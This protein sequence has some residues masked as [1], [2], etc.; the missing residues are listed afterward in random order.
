M[1]KSLFKKSIS[2]A[3]TLLLLMTIMCMAFNVNAA[4]SPN[5]IDK[6][7]TGSLTLTK[8]EMPDSEQA[9]GGSTGEQTDIEKL[10][11]GAIPLADVTF[12]MYKIG[13]I[14]TYFAPDGKP[15]PTVEEAARYVS[16]NPE[17]KTYSQTTNKDG[18]AK[19]T[20]LP[21]AIYYVVETDCPAQ[22]TKV[23]AP[24]VLSVPMTNADG[25]AWMYDIYS[26]PKN[27][28]AY[29]DI[30]L[31]KVDSVTKEEL[32]GAKFTLYHSYD[33]KTYTEYMTDL[34]TDEN[35]EF[36]VANLPSQVYYRFVES[37]TSDPSYILDTTAFYE[38]YIDGT[39]DV[40][41]NNNV[42]DD[43][44]IVVDNETPEIHKY[45]LDGEKG[46]KGIDNT[47]NY[48]DIVHWEIDTTIFTIVEKMATYTIVDTM[49]K[50][51]KYVDA[52][53]LVDNKKL[54]K[55][56]TD[57]TV[58]QSGLEVTF[59]IN[60]AVLDGGKEVN[61]YF[62]TELTTD[63]PLA[64]D[65]PNS[66]K[67]IY[68]ND[69]NT[70]STFEKQSEIPNVHTGGYSF[71]KT[72]GKSGLK[73]TKFAIYRTEKDADNDTNRIDTQVSGEDGLVEF[74]GLEYGGFSA[75]EETKNVNGTANGSTDYWIAEIEAPEGFNLIKEPFKVTVN[76][77]SHIASNN[78]NVVNTAQ[79]ELP[80]T[81]IVGG[82]V[83]PICGA[84]LF[85]SGLVLF[86]VVRI[87]KKNCIK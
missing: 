21:L 43:K 62:N 65:I 66:S 5:L 28:T 41:I 45:V 8:Y 14:D 29:S 63:A 30:N 31:K 86:G 33:N 80:Q 13:D 36:T 61:L 1:I 68:T 57:Y 84:I 44:T 75:D 3:L 34:T 87:K 27:Q 83:I 51:L 20:N 52:E 11:D 55:E 77:T 37:S 32:P 53:L 54:L 59:A 76:A 9:V 35:G 71:I 64:Q 49:S 82:E 58:S 78:E 47:A 18:I 7:K 85:V 81:G 70:D 69:I 12:T 10:P 67:L 40:I 19:F 16:S 39:G 72:N 73:D 25:T 38:F 60:P 56:N 4:V 24:F 15:L 79:F 46:T 22:V 26:Y 50:G 48:G 42:V 23:T 6:T 2:L 17:T 74:K